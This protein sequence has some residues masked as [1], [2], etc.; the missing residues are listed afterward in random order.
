MNPSTVSEFHEIKYVKNDLR[1][2]NH[3]KL[4][5]ANTTSYRVESVSFRG[6]FLWN[7]LDD[8]IKQELTLACFKNK[9]KRWAGDQCTC[10]ICQ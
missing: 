6:R 4:P 7:T 3:C 8:N 10:R 9:I 5:N 1:K 2:Q